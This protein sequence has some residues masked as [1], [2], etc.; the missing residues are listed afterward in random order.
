MSHE[1]GSVTMRVPVVE[2][3]GIDVEARQGRSL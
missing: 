1:D 3:D 2:F